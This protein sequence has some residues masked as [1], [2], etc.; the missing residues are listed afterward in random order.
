MVTM[1]NLKVPRL[2]CTCTWLRRAK[3]LGP[4]DVMRGVHLSSPSVAYRHL[5]KLESSGLLKKNDYGE[6]IL[7]EK[8]RVNGFYWV[9][10]YLLPRNMFYFFFF[11]GL[12][13]LEVVVIAIHY[14]VETYEFKVFFALGLSITGIAMSFFLLEG[15]MMLRKIKVKNDT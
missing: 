6:Y 8:A 13:I 1:S 14:A 15:I 4:R 5:Q 7:K 10:R 2:M 3:P 11:F 12:F 9:G